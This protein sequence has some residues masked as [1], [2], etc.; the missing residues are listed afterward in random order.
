[1]WVLLVAP[2]EIM[3]SNIQGET[4][5]GAIARFDARG[6]E[7]I[8]FDEFVF[9]PAENDYIPDH[10]ATQPIRHYYFYEPSNPPRQM[11][12]WRKHL[13][14]SNLQSGG[15]A[16]TGTDFRL[17]PENLLLRHYIFRNQEHAFEKYSGRVYDP[18]E[19]SRGWHWHGAGQ[20]TTRFA[21]PPPDQL[22]TL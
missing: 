11:R 12:A 7:V 13:N 16:L 10:F 20:S 3:Q 9:L 5:A 17:A 2:D 14:L 19:V 6:Y 4:L 18:A 21:F 1:D 15:H 22:E 8:N